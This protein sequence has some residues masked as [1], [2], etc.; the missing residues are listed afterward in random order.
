MA[1]PADADAV[2]ATQ[3]VDPFSEIRKLCPELLDSNVRVSQTLSS[4]LEGQ[5]S[6][7]LCDLCQDVVLSALTE[8]ERQKHIT[9]SDLPFTLYFY[10]LIFFLHC[11]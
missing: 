9:V 2:L 4:V 10:R 3:V 1:L 7:E 6:G 11:D 5:V 8:E